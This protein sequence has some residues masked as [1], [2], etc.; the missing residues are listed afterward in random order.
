MGRIANMSLS[1]SPQNALAPLFE[2]INNSIQAIED[3][4]GK[5]NLTKGRIEIEVLRSDTE[6]PKP[7]GFIVRDNGIGFNKHNLTSFL[8]ADTRYKLARGG[9]GVGRFLWLKVFDTTHIESTFEDGKTLASMVFDFV[10]DDENQVRNVRSQAPQKKSGTTITLDPFLPE[11]AS[12]CP[13]KA[14]TIKAKIIGHFV[15]YFVNMHLPKIIYRRG[16]Q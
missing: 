5:D 2:A 16:S 9:R 8:T 14:S 7:R 13:S 3:K 6:E 1:P 12:H 4:Y 11:F 15:S 10:L